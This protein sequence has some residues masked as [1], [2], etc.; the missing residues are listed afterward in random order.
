MIAAY[1]SLRL[2]EKSHLT[3]NHSVVFHC[4]HLRFHLA[5]RFRH[6]HRQAITVIAVKKSVDRNSGSD[7]AAKPPQPRRHQ[8]T[9]SVIAR[10]PK[11]AYIAKRT[12]ETH[13]ETRRRRR[14]VIVKVNAHNPAI[15]LGVSLHF[16]TPSVA[17]VTPQCDFSNTFQ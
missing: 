6:S 12:A 3:F 16:E 13:T 7:I 2:G 15:S 11:I 1:R 10:M 5:E 14:L 9:A 4:T 8:R 17:V